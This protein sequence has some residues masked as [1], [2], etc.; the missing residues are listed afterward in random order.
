MGLRTGAEYLWS[1][2]KS[3]AP[4]VPLRCG[5]GYTQVPSPSYDIS[6]D[7]TF[8]SDTLTILEIEFPTSST[9]QYNFSLGA[10]V[11]WSQIHLDVAYSYTALSRKEPTV[12][13]GQQFNGLI[14]YGELKTKN[15]NLSMTFTGYF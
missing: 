4:T 12:V 10:G 1:T 14:T 13:F 15:H 7:Y 9:A 3:F 11:Y 2:G 6:S 8:V 5:F